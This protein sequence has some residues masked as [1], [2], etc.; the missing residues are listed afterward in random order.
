VGNIVA[1]VDP[2][3]NRTTMV[4]D[5]LNRLVQQTDPLGHS[6]TFAYDAASRLVS[7]TDRDGRVFNFS[8]DADDRQTGQTWISGGSTVNLLTFT[9]DAASNMLTAAS[10]AGT[11]TMAYDALDR[12]TSE[13]EPFTAVLTFTYD[14]VGNRTLVQDSSGGYTTSIY[15]AVDRLTTREFGGP[16]Q[17]PLRIDFT[18]TNRNQIAT[19][20]RYSDLAGT[21][22]V[23]S[24][25][26]TYDAA[27]RLTN[28]QQLSSTNA[29]LSNFTYTY[30]L[31]NRLARSLTDPDGRGSE[32]TTR[33]GP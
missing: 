4:F 10:Y 3:G 32:E 24:S 31:A 15:D 19:E 29:L 6:A 18:Y 13:L 20:T 2:V 11:Y 5:G 23:G 27:M 12:M 22:K 26:F 16:S 25:A 28:I 7:E 17:T 21:Q 14:A 1:R 33:H 30:D 9:Y 8:Y